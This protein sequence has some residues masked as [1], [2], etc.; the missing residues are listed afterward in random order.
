M[1][2]SKRTMCDCCRYSSV[3][4]KGQESI[5]LEN[6]QQLP[7]NVGDEVEI[8]IEE[9]K[10]VLAALI[11]FLFPGIIFLAILLLLKSWSQVGSFFIAIFGICIYYL[12]VKIVLRKKAKYF[13]VKI[14]RKL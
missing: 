14:L 12:I 3:C 5:V 4:G 6:E 7:L 2:F 9:K 10:T 13:N 8:G 11:M 1:R